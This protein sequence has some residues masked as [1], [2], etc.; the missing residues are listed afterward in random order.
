MNAQLMLLL[1]IQDLHI[2]KTALLEEPGF[3]S[4]QVQHFHIDPEKAAAALDEKISELKKGL[5]PAI[6]TRFEKGFPTRGRMVVP[7][8]GGVCYGCYVSIPTSRVGDGNRGV[9]TCESCG[10]SFQ[11]ISA[12]SPKPTSTSPRT[13]TCSP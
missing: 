11:K 3:D 12:G 2:H 9:E 10:N 5:E 1:E 13:T 6:Q 8:I 7:V 4:V